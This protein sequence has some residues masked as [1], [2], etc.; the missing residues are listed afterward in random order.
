MGLCFCSIIAPPYALSPKSPSLDSMLQG[1]LPH[2]R[3]QLHIF[4]LVPESLDG[5]QVE[6][7]PVC[8]LD[9]VENAEVS[10]PSV[11]HNER[12]VH[13]AYTYKRAFIRTALLPRATLVQKARAV[14][15]PSY[16]ASSVGWIRACDD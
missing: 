15:D 11:A 16:P 3:E 8:L 14:L 6:F 2:S 9:R 4:V 12:L 13:I 7:A 5:S 10:Y 1:A